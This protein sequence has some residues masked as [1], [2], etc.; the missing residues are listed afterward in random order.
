MSRPSVVYWNN[1]PSPYVVERFDALAARGNLTFEAWFNTRREPDRSWEIDETTWRFAYRYIPERSLAGRRLRLPVPELRATRPHLLVSLHASASFAL[2]SMAAR[3]LG[4]RT[5]FRVLPTYDA[6]VERSR[7]KELFKHLLFRTVD[8]VKVP[9]PDGAQMA[10]R[11]GVPSERIHLV[12]QSIAVEHYQRALHADPVARTRRREELDLHGS[13]FV[14]VGRLW[15]GKGVDYLLEAYR[16]VRRERTEVCLLLIGDGVDEAQYRA[17]ARDLPGVTF[18]GFVQHR[19]MPD[20]YAL[21]DVLVFPTLG[22][23]HGLVVEEAMV[24]GRP[25][26]CTEAAGDIRRR[27][28]DGQA[29]YIV[30]PADA[31]ALAANMLRLAGDETL[32]AR[33]PRRASVSQLSALMSSGRR[34]SRRS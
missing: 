27:L 4:V 1:I 21:G 15:S 8:G 30:P 6:W 11:Y 3:A 16:Q 9:G 13:V 20:W 12:T 10:Q 34:I 5:A 31:P 28:P 33:S 14:Y 19:G 25:V 23:P 17:T 32:R 29:G 24:A 26:I 22:D 7:L 18:A 2:G